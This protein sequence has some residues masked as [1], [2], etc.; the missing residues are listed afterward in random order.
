MFNSSEAT[1]PAVATI[2]LISD[3]FLFLPI[4]IL[5]STVTGG[6]ATGEYNIRQVMSFLNY[7][8]TNT[9]T[10]DFTV[11][12]DTLIF[13]EGSGLGST[14]SFN[15]PIID[16]NLEEDGETINIQAIIQGSV[17]S[18]VGGS[19]TSNIVQISIIDDDGESQPQ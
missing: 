15:V 6:S 1:S 3:T 10:D 2:E 12:T 8:V 11:T 4:T 13:D 9:G 7:I 14:I 18:F 17:G 16:D 19:D 5:V